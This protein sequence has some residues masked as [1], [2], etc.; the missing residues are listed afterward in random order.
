MTEP[1]SKL[2]QF[3]RQLSAVVTPVLLAQG[4]TRGKPGRDYHRLS[5]RGE[6]IYHLV[7]F[8]VAPASASQHGKYTVELGIY[9]PAFARK[10]D[11]KVLKP[12]IRYSNLDVRPRLGF[13]FTPQEDR[14]WPQL[15]DETAQVAQL[16]EVIDQIVTLGLPWFEVNDT[17]A[18]AAL[19]NVGKQPKRGK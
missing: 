17:D 1:N 3:D 4:F 18:N 11:Q 14:W 7:S 13:L 5:P 10:M 19:Y 16:R 9:Y 12:S 15:A 8:Q 2:V 6:D